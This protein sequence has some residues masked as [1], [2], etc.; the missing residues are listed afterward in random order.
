MPMTKVNKSYFE[1]FVDF[2]KKQKSLISRHFNGYGGEKAYQMAEAQRRI[3]ERRFR[4]ALMRVIRDIRAKIKDLFSPDEIVE[5]IEDYSKTKPFDDL[6]G[7]IAEKMVTGQLVGQRATW[8]EA[9]AESTKGR[10]IYQALKKETSAPAMRAAI[11]D[12]LDRN[13]RLI[14]SV[15]P[16]LAKRMSRL[17]YEKQQAGW[18]PE[19][20]AREMQKMA[21]TLSAGRVKLIARTE[22]A[23]AASALMEARCQQ[24]GVEWYFWRSCNDERV[25]HS[26]AQMNGVLCRWS[27]PP[28]PEA[29]FGGSGGGRYHPGGIYNCRCIA[30]PVIELKDVQFPVR[31]HINGKVMSVGSYKALQKLAR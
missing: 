8:R 6:A 26:H 11:D 22:T 31:V 30:T 16:E 25:R 2:T 20:I 12:I 17:A 9:A 3:G 7:E 13:Y 24:L 29:M 5:A 4:S 14:K 27:D 21:P 1:R 23:K 18:R 19:D 15:P 10:V 28:N